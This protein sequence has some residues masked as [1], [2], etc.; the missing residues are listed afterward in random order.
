MNYEPTNRTANRRIA[1]YFAGCAAMHMFCDLIRGETMHKLFQRIFRFVRRATGFVAQYIVMREI[2]NNMPAATP[3][4]SFSELAKSRINI[5]SSCPY[6]PSRRSWHLP[7]AIWPTRLAT[8]CNF[9]QEVAGI[10]RIIFSRP[11]TLAWP[12][13]VLCTLSPRF[14]NS[15]M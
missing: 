4:S 12:N 1:N 10:C 7:T 6:S 5:Q 11:L 2:S 14:S 3:T 15:P 13:L 8:N 9:L